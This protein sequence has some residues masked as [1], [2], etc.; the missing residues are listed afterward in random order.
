[1]KSCH[2]AQRDP[3]GLTGGDR[4]SSPKQ[5]APPVPTFG[6]GALYTGAS[7]ELRVV[8]TIGG[9][10]RPNTVGLQPTATGKDEGGQGNAQGS[11]ILPL[12]P[13]APKR[14]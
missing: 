7:A 3:C 10:P 5:I 14:Q 9:S 12:C 11:R 2:A 4:D 6:S 8:G 13:L 1:M